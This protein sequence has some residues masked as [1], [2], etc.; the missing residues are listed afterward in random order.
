MNMPFGKFK[1]VDLEDCPLS[2]LSWLTENIELREPLSSEVRRELAARFDVVPRTSSGV[3]VKPEDVVLVRQ[4][5]DAGYRSVASR[6]HPDV[7]GPPGE[8]QRLNQVVG[9]L[10]NQL[11]QLAGGGR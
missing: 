9:S 10:R 6:L 11:R 8:M 3:V 4:I 5:V 1:G 7:G 2:Y